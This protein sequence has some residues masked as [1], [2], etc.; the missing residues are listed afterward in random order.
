MERT[1]ADIEA[2][3][4]SLR[5]NLAEYRRLA[6]EHRE[7]DQGFSAEKLL[8]LVAVLERKAAELEGELARTATPA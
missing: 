2:E 7:H 8:E 1:L 4:A 6:E 5:G 3:V